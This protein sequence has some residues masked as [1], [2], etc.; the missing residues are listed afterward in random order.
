MT[1]LAMKPG[2]THFSADRADRADRKAQPLRRHHLRSLATQLSDLTLPLHQQAAVET[3]LL[4]INPFRPQRGAGE[5][6]FYA[7]G[8]KY[9]GLQPRGYRVHDAVAELCLGRRL[10]RDEVVHHV[11]EN[12][13]DNHPLNLVVCTP[14]VHRFLHRKGGTAGSARYLAPVGAGWLVSAAVAARL[15]PLTQTTASVGSCL[16]ITCACFAG[17]PVRALRTGEVRGST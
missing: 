7:N 9:Y 5:L 16:G 8:R 17:G 12:R 14:G 13:R 15:F 10:R 2:R 4:D 3:L 11:N 6:E 1:T